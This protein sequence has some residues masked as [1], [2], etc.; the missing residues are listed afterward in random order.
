[1][2]A[3]ENA[4]FQRHTMIDRDA[5]LYFDVVANV[6]IGINVNPFAK[7]TVMTN[8]CSFSNLAVLPYSG[9]FTNNGF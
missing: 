6:H 7:N 8:D 9:A 5:V 4:V 3:T 2:G 1:M